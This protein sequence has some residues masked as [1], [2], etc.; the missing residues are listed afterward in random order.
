MCIIR[1][2]AKEIAK[3]TGVN[4]ELKE[5]VMQ[6]YYGKHVTYMFTNKEAATLLDDHLGLSTDGPLSRAEMEAYLG[7]ILVG[8]R[9]KEILLDGHPG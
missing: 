3:R 9:A 4:Y 2:Y 6:G 7:G 1:K 8:I 5:N